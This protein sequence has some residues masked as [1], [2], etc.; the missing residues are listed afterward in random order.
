MFM[1]SF[2][3]RR[4][5]ALS[6][7]AAVGALAMASLAQTAPASA[8]GFSGPLPACDNASVLTRVKTQ[9]DRAES[10]YNGT[11][12]LVGFESAYELALDNGDPSE[13]TRR[14]CSVRVL[15]TSDQ[16]LTAYYMVEQNAGFLGISWGV[17]ACL[18][19]N[20]DWRVYG[21]HCQTVRPD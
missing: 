5:A 9:L 15:T 21:R 10:L 20:D 7:V 3:T 2:A 17:E 12:R 8:F 19:S 11:D 13:L 14:Y 6:L 4:S 16:P 1:K 18:P